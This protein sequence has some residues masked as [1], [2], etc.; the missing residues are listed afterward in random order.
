MERSAPRAVSRPDEK[1]RAS[2][3]TP[4]RTAE[5]LGRSIEAQLLKDLSLPRGKPGWLD[6]AAQT[7]GMDDQ[8]VTV[9]RSEQRPRFRAMLLGLLPFSKK[10]DALAA[11]QI[12]DGWSF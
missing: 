9:R 6:F 11:D 2:W 4:E 3:N 7:R 12:L 1:Q 5:D 8:R 10:K